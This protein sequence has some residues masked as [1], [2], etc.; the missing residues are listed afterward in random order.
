MPARDM[1]DTFNI[2][3]LGISSG[4]HIVFLTMYADGSFKEFNIK[5]ELR[6]EAIW[7]LDY[8]RAGLHTLG[9]ALSPVYS[10]VWDELETNSSYKIS[11]ESI[12]KDVHELINTFLVAINVERERRHSKW[13]AEQKK[14]KDKPDTIQVT[15]ERPKVTIRVG[16]NA[17]AKASVSSEYSEE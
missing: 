16:G 8:L 3:M 7:V 9:A 2:L 13:E 6:R 15:S 1:E 4:R 12:D 10:P 14:D 17:A 5:R 11:R